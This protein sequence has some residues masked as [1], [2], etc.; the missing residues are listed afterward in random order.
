MKSH[1]GSR[2]SI[3]KGTSNFCRVNLSPAVVHF[4]HCITMV[5]K[6]AGFKT[7]FP[8]NRVAPSREI[9]GGVSGT[10]D[11]RFYLSMIKRRCHLPEP[12]YVIEFLVVK[13]MITASGVLDPIF[14][15]VSIFFLSG[16]SS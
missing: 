15:L 16:K 8:H 12:A 3:D 4:G 6:L 11:K 1:S 5:L 2:E 10:L 9:A 7:W 14:Y 13:F